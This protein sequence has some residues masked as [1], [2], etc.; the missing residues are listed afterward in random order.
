MATNMAEVFYL[1]IHTFAGEVGKL[2]T[3]AILNPSLTV[4]TNV[5]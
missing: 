1:S 3:K 2:D 5:A 4:A